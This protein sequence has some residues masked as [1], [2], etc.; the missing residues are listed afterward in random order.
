[1]SSNINDTKNE[2]ENNITNPD[3]IFG[4]FKSLITLTLHILLSIVIGSLIIYS[5]KV[6]QSNILPTDSNCFPYTDSVP[7]VKPINININLKN[8]QGELLSEKIKFPYETNSSNTILNF[9]RKLKLSPN[10]FGLENYF[11]SIV[12]KIIAFDYNAYNIFYNTLNSAP[13]ILIA[14]IGPIV[15]FFY[16]IILSLINIVYLSYLWFANLS[17]LFQQNEN[18]SGTGS[19]IWE[20]ITILQPINYFTS[21]LLSILFICLFFISLTTVIP[22]LSLTSIVLSLITIISVVGVNNDNIKYNVFNCIKDNL[23]YRK[24]T[25]MTLLSIAIIILTFIHFGTPLGIISTITILLLYFNIIPL[26]LFTDITPKNL[27]ELAS[28]KQATKKCN[29][30]YKNNTSTKNNSTKNPIQEVGNVIENTVNNIT[31]ILPTVKMKPLQLPGE[32]TLPLI[33][34][35]KVKLPELQI[36][37]EIDIKIPKIELP[38]IE[39]PKQISNQVIKDQEG[40]IKNLNKINNVLKK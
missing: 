10:T 9:L 33:T 6:S 5:C 4:F 12:E 38:N 36:P 29:Y 30:E 19:P 16:T 21:I 17:W 32:I 15:T 35:Q 8:I 1:M 23:K 40:V 11:I 34:T 31:N 39:L 3:K 2:M 7:I 20:P 22:F 18:R 27:S 25:I 14:F 24:K 37:S 13:E 28:Y 26:S